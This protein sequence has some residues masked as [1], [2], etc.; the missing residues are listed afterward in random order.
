MDAPTT[1]LARTPPSAGGRRL[2]KTG[3]APSAAFVD[4]MAK[5]AV[6]HRAPHGIFILQ[7]EIL[8]EPRWRGVA[9]DETQPED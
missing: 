5:F 8:D 1:V 6:E 4:F 7:E 3:I 2:Q 9:I